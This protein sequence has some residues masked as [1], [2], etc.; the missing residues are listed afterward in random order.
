MHAEDAFLFLGMQL[1][2]RRGRPQ[3]QLRHH[4]QTA[5]TSRISLKVSRILLVGHVLHHPRHHFRRACGRLL[6]GKVGLRLA[7]RLQ[8]TRCP[9]ARQKTTRFSNAAI[10]AVRTV[11][12]TAMT[13]IAANTVAMFSWRPALR[14]T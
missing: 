14:T 6:E 3:L 4:C 7:I 5:P 9:Q 12:R 2:D 8:P 10:N 11:A 13:M 1:H